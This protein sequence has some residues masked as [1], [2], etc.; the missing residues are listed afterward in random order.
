MGV[1]CPPRLATVSRLAGNPSWTSPELDIVLNIQQ[2]FSKY[3]NF[4]LLQS[5]KMRQINIWQTEALGG[6]LGRLKV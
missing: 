5:N 2:V 6:I 1:T 4:D 3:L